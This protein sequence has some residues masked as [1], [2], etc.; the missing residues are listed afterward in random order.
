MWP[1]FQRHLKPHQGFFIPNFHIYR[2]DRYQGRKGGTAIT[3]RKGIPHSH[4]DLSPLVSLEATGVCIPVRN[5]VVLLAAVYKS[6]GRP[7]SD[8]DIIEL[9]DIK[10]K[11]VLAGDLNT[12]HQCGNGAVSNP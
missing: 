8:A 7:W 2:N 9:L 11:T 3:V 10:S 12:K 5:D 1:C 6:P 4:I